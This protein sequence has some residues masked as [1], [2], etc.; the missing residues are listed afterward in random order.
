M[1]HGRLWRTTAA[2]LSAG[3]VLTA[4]PVLSA[5]LT[6][7]DGAVSVTYQSPHT[8]D[9]VC[10]AVEFATALFAQ[11]SVPPVLDPVTIDVVDDVGQ[12]CV[13]VYHCGEQLIEL[14]SPAVL[15]ERLDGS[16][17][18]GHLTT[19]TYFKSIVVHEMTHAATDNVPCP[20]KN[21]V[22]TSE[23]VS[24]AMQV[25]S[26][27]PEEQ[28][29]FSENAGLTGRVSSQELSPII[30]YMAPDKFAQKVWAHFNQ[31]DAPCEFIGELTRGERLL[32]HAVFHRD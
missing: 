29:V 22:V 2:A 3:L 24:Y 14:L 21:C 17:A 20:F 32:D 8:A 7:G 6:C 16:G 28:R 4:L 15:R 18:F 26:L 30:L 23:Y 1:R 5:T 13:G 12:G 27:T 19:D 31:H 25:M 9:L 10:E 11:C